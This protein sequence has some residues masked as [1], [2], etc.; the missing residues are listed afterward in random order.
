MFPV[1]GKELPPFFTFSTIT[2]SWF[3]HPESL[4][5]V[6]NVTDSVCE[7]WPFWE[8]LKERTRLVEGWSE[9]RHKP[10]PWVEQAAEAGR[11]HIH[12]LPRKENLPFLLLQC[13][14]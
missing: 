7:S 6:W 11:G 1:P 12:S 3:H 10:R 9:R 13:S 2:V 8:N 4:F 5:R 14:H